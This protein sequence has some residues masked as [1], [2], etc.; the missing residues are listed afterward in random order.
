MEEIV[1]ESDVFIKVVQFYKDFPC[2][3]N[4]FH[5]FYYNTDVRKQ[6]FTILKECLLLKIWKGCHRGNLKKKL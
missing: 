4:T 2:L 1:N 6:I 3:C 5:E